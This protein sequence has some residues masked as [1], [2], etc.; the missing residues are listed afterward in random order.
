[1]GFLLTTQSAQ[2]PLG[3]DAADLVAFLAIVVTLLGLLLT[4]I[5]VLMLRTLNKM[6]ERISEVKIEAASAADGATN[7]VSDLRRDL[8]S[9]IR[10]LWQAIRSPGPVAPPRAL[11]DGR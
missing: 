10:T 4:A 9:D 7:A 5:G 8:S 6:D 2:T 1:V 3:F 11:E